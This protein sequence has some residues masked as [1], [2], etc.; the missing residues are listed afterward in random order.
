MSWRAATNGV[1]TNHLANGSN[2]ASSGTRI[3]TFLV[4]TSLIKGT[5]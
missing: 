5:L 3:D 4:N 2:S 1:V